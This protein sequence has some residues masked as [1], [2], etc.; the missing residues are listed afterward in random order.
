MFLLAAWQQT[1]CS[2]PAHAYS[3]ILSRSTVVLLINS[4]ISVH[5]FNR[6]AT[7]VALWPL[8]LC[9]ENLGS[10]QTFALQPVI[11][12]DLASLHCRGLEKLVRAPCFA[13]TLV[14]SFLCD[15]VD[16]LSVKGHAH[17][18][19][20]HGRPAPWSINCTLLYS[21]LRSSQKKV[22]TH[23]ILPQYYLNLP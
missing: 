11:S 18:Y 9:C 7:K 14:L 13:F 17:S 2:V 12:W 21:P 8:N 10:V 4:S 5:V 19:S 20:L 6:A 15:A 1:C 23:Q 3:L 22:P 16:A